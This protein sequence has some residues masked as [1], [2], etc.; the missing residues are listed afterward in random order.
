MQSV[1]LSIVGASAAGLA[2]AWYLARQGVPALVYEAQAPYQPAERTLIV[3]PAFLR[4]L[5]FDPREAILYRVRGYELI[6]RGASA[7]IPLREPDIVLD[8]AR[9]LHLLVHRVKEAGGEVFFGHRLMDIRTDRVPYILRFATGE[10]RERWVVAWRFL[11]ADGLSGQVSRIAQAD[12]LEEVAL[13]Q[14]RVLLPGDLPPDTVRVWFDRATTR[15]FYWLIPESPHTGAAGLVAKTPGEARRLLEE[16]LRAQ[17]LEPLAW[18]EGQAPLFPLSFGRAPMGDGRILLAGDAAGQVK[19]T[20]VGGLVAGMRGGLAAA[21][22]L[23]AGTFY[24]AESRLLRR[25]LAFHALVRRVLDAFTDEDYDAL[26]GLLNRR[27]CSVLGR[28][29]RDDLARGLGPILLSQPRWLLLGARALVRGLR[30]PGNRSPET[31][32]REGAV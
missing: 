9:F 3:T 26:L 13:C 16:F 5:D 10:N 6:S 24:D 23:A 28:Y 1:P 21:R 29:H 18:Q 20:T 12:G 7:C 32:R 17:G 19:G 2:A 25:E 27:A 8:R 14:A 15:F 31:S 4:L 30:G 22:S 11:G